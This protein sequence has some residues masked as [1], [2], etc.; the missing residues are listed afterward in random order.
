MLAVL[1]QLRDLGNTLSIVSDVLGPVEPGQAVNIEIVSTAQELLASDPLS[2]VGVST[3][4]PAPAAQLLASTSVRV[5]V[6]WNVYALGGRY[7]ALLSPGVDYLMN[8]VTP[9]P[10]AG[11]GDTAVSFLF[12]PPIIEML[13]REDA[14]E[15]LRIRIEPTI[16]LEAM[17]LLDAT[18]T[19]P[20]HVTV[21]V[22]DPAIRKRNPAQFTLELDLA[23]LEIP[24][25]LVLFRHT[26]FRPFEN[27]LT[28][29]FALAIF[30]GGAPFR[31]VTELLNKTLTRIEEIARPLKALARFA[32]FLAKLPLLRSALSAPP[33]V[34]TLAG[35]VEHLWNIHMDVEYTLG[36]DSWDE[37]LRADDRVSSLIFLGPP[38]AAVDCFN[39]SEFKLGQGQLRITAD[40]S[41]IML[42]PDLIDVDP[43]NPFPGVEI[44]EHDPDHNFN[45]SMSSVRW[46]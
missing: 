6:E 26:R 42:V 9:G 33:M 7:P 5:K 23:P 41:L 12:S 35:S 45:N 29:G 18:A 1:D 30:R 4:L 3:P 22:P 37:D 13:T 31:D 40:L 15:P 36:F 39:D 34:R 10:N 16:T 25:L 44:V 32:A 46:V 28:R 17:L 21:T 27:D 19:G 8:A 24:S 2:L 14:P 43:V 11:H 20:Q 38:T